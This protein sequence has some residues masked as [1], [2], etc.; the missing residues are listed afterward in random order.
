MPANQNIAPIM[1]AR[2]TIVAR[3]SLP[4]KRN[5]KSVFKGSH[6]VNPSQDNKRIGLQFEKSGIENAK[7]LFI[8]P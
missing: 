3:P 5:V 6:N 4:I 2:D 8:S 7:K 1:M